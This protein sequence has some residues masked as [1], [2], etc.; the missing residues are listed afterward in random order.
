[1][2]PTLIAYFAFIVIGLIFFLAYLFF[3]QPK[4]YQK[5]YGKRFE[6]KRQFPFEL[7]NNLEN[8]RGSIRVFAICSG[9]LLFLCSCFFL[10][11]S[12]LF[13]SL[14]GMGITMAI[15]GMLSSVFFSL[16]FLLSAE[17]DV[18]KHLFS[19]VTFGTTSI[20]LDSLYVIGFI[21]LTGETGAPYIFV[22][23]CIAFGIAKL[24]FML[25]PKLSNWSKMDSSIDQDGNVVYFRPSPFWLAFTEWILLILHFA[26]ALASILGFL[27]FFLPY[28]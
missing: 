7:F 24:I 21:H 27:L 25:N 5:R 6:I 16:V 12:I 15:A 23:L 9:V 1:M 17:V 4:Q 26:S 28:I 11:A 8:E 10:I 18:K 19:F 13:P 2:K 20:L 22:G 14:L 3:V